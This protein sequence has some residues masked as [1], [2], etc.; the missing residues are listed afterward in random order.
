MVPFVGSP[1]EAERLRAIGLVRNDGR[2]TAPIEPLTQ[3]V[4]V[5]GLPASS[6]FATLVR[7]ISRCAGGQSRAWSPVRR[8]ER[9]W[10]LASVIAWV[11]VL[12][13]HAS[14]RL[15]AFAPPFCARG[16]AMCFDLGTVDHLDFKRMAFAG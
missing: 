13:R 6:F 9:R 14:D 7:R 4:A 11:F 1:V 15:P 3:F 12:R 16:R 10:P 2:C 5:V 8:M